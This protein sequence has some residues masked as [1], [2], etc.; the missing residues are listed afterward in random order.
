MQK[1]WW[2]RDY[3]QSISQTVGEHKLVK[4]ESEKINAKAIPQTVGEHKLEKVGGK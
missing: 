1:F 2:L 4:G 3:V